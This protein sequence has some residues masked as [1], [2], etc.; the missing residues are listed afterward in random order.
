MR[1]SNLITLV[2]VALM[3]SFGIH[4]QSKA[5]PAPPLQYFDYRLGTIPLSSSSCADVANGVG[6]R[7]EAETG[8]KVGRSECTG[9]NEQGYQVTISYL[10][11]GPMER[12]KDLRRVF[13]A[14]NYSEY[15]DVSTGTDHTSPDTDAMY[16]SFKDCAADS[17]A[18][19]SL[20]RAQTGI[21][22]VATYCVSAL[23]GGFS[24]HIDGFGTPQTAPS[25]FAQ[26]LRIETAE[27][28]GPGRAG[29]SDGEAAGIVV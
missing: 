25:H 27:P 9:Q 7:F 3:G 13:L 24:L 1:I 26:Q 4:S 14:F 15:G 10:A 11:A 8:L 22:P 21:E 12:L 16:T 6:Q 28:S 19:A 23:M 18:Q 2:F 20:Y 29:R 5:D 17:A